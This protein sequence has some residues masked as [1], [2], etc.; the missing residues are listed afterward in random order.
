K[1]VIVGHVDHGKSTVVG[2]IFYDTGT[3]PEGRVEAIR[4]MCKKRGMPFEWAFVMD[5]LQAE[6]D[7]G[8]TIDVSQVFFNS[9]KRR[10][11]L[12]D[13][14]GHHEFIK[15]MVTGAASADAAVLVI[16]AEHG[17]R[18][19]TRRHAYLLHLLGLRRVVVALSKMDLV[20]YSQDRYQEVKS[21]CLDYLTNIG[22]D[23]AAIEVVPVSGRDGDNIVT[24]STAMDWYTGPTLLEQLDHF[25]SP[26]PDDELPLRLPVQD[27]YK[28]DKRRIVAGRIESGRLAV[29]DELTFSPSNKSAK[30]KSIETWNSPTTETTAGAGQSVGITLDQQ[31]FVERGEIASHVKSPPCLTN[32]F[33][34]KLFWLGRTPVT[35]GSR[36]R[37]KLNTASYVVEVASIEKVINVEDLGETS[38][39]QVGRY[40]VGEVIF[41]SR[42][43]MA[44]DAF[45][46]NPHTGRFVLVDNDDI[47]GGGLIDMDGFPDQRQRV[48]VRSSNIDTN[49]HGVN[50]DQRWHVNGHKSGIVWLTGLPGSGKTT[51]SFGLEKALFDNGY[52]AYVLDGE[53]IRQHL[54]ED[55]SFSPEDRSENIRRVGQSA[56]LFAHAGMI[57]ITAF[58]SPYRTDRD[59]VRA[60]APNLFHEVYL[61][62]PID[63][64]EARD[65]SGSYQKARRGEITD[66][67]GVSAPYEKPVAPE[68]V[69]DTVNQ[70]VEQSLEQL[71]TYVRKAFSR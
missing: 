27:V 29:G 48:G 11:V 54:S 57:S 60:L 46:E 58:I 16:D 43:L 47:A 33:R 4:D 56:R 2:R 8:I 61:D 7:Q 20:D 39:K 37:L 53:N 50:L 1:I 24:R 40:A 22:L 42:G 19:E 9:S 68:L 34:A 70:S 28:F 44:V 10:Y 38:A 59:R 13:A 36:Y 63:V 30:I 17:V 21:E 64:C 62:A 31:I 71:I 65:T 45:T 35:V 18:E 6:R 51:L 26:A 55:L 49:A 52:H 15:N 5:A 66:F 25:S 32:I 3:L 12:I 14:P 69:I 23:P 67:T 41:K